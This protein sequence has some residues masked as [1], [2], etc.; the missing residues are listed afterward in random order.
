MTIKLKEPASI[1]KDFNVF[2]YKNMNADNLGRFFELVVHENDS[3]I[4]HIPLGEYLSGDEIKIPITSAVM[5]W[6]IQSG[7]LPGYQKALMIEPGLNTEGLLEIEDIIEFEVN[8]ED[9][10]SGVIFKVGV[11]LDSK[12]GIA[13][14][15]T[16]NVLYDA[17]N[18]AN[19]TVLN[20]GVHLKKSG[21]RNSDLSVGILDLKKIGI[22]T[23]S[24]ET[25]FEEDELCFF[26]AG[27]TS[28]GT[29]VDGPFPCNFHLG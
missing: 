27:S 3:F 2:S 15:N 9:I 22:G 21:F 29:Y 5:K 8:Y 14:L 24:D 7:H 6:A 26:I 12:T 19:R 20:F 11:D 16:K 17:L 25:L 1:T 10:T 4:N 23:C 18:E 28:T 13:I